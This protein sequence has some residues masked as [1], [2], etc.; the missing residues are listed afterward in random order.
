MY[1]PKCSQEQ[2]SEEMRFCSRCGFSLSA[3]R[4][5]VVSENTLVEKGAGA[6][7]GERSCGQKA[8]LRGAWMML[9]GLVL[10]IFVGLLSAV[11]DDFAVFFLLPFFCF[12]FGVVSV[13]YGVFLA[14]KRARKKAALKANVVPM[15]PGQT[16]IPA[17]LPAARITPIESFPSK[18]GATAEMIQ[19]PSVTENTTRL[20]DEDSDP[21]RG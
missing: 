9:A 17:A 13:F 16:G 4:E 2:V 3:V 7:T 12:V 6:Q 10:T 8:V 14:D 11:D 1:C 21:R 15:M 5:L 19:P 20:L 18:R